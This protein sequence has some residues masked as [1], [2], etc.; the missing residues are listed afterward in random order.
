M[1]QMN[2]SMTLALPKSRVR[3][4]MKCEHEHRS[5]RKPQPE[6]GAH[7]V[8]LF[9]RLYQNYPFHSLP[10]RHEL[11]SDSTVTELINAS[12]EPVTSQVVPFSV[13]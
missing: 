3:N 7:L 5:D 6:K 1:L 12:H 11:H 9:I 2:A 10:Q 13:T 8:H 4:T